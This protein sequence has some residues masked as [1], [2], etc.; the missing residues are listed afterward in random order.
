MI[1]NK[2]KLKALAEKHNVINKPYKVTKE[3][4]QKATGTIIR[5]GYYPKSGKP[6]VR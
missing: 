3:E 4:Y 1:T 6:I 2:L 5:A